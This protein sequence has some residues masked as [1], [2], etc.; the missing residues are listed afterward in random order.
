MSGHS[1]SGLVIRLYSGLLYFEAG[2]WK[3]WRSICR[4]HL[5]PNH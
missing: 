5:I 3:P 2:F 1:G 4:W